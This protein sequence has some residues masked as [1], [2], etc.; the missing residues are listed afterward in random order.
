MN[1]WDYR[2]N[3]SSS[4][5]QGHV[6]QLF[7]LN[8]IGFKIDYIYEDQNKLRNIN[9]EHY[10]RSFIQNINMLLEQREKEGYELDKIT[11]LNNGLKIVYPKMT[12]KSDDDESGAFSLYPKTA[13]CPKCHRYVRLDHNEDMCNCNEKLIQFTF[14]AHCDECGVNYPID[15]MSNVLNDCKQCHL[16]NG[17]RIINWTQADDLLSYS[18]SCIRCKYTEKLVLFRCDHK[19]HQSG[20]IRSRRPPS[21]FRG[22]AARSGSIIHPKILTFPDI[23]VIP[24]TGLSSNNDIDR[25]RLFSNSFN[26]FFKSLDFK[27]Q[28]SLLYMPDF[29]DALK[30]ET[31]FW[32]KDHIIELISYMDLNKIQIDSWDLNSRIKFI[33]GLLIEAY[34][35]IIV[36]NK[37]KK[38]RNEYG[39]DEIEE[40]LNRIKDKSLD[41]QEQQGTSLLL[42]SQTSN[43]S[44]TGTHVKLFPE[45]GYRDNGLFLE[46]LGIEKVA[47]VSN[48]EM[49]QALLGVVEGSM[50]DKPLLFRTIN[51]NNG[52]PTVYVRKMP[53]EAVYFKL[54]SDK[55]LN[56]L[57]YNGKV[58][59]P[60][61][62]LKDKN[63]GLLRTLVST[64]EEIK[65]EVYKL[66]HTFSHTLIQNASIN[67]GLETQ[68]MSEMIFS[69]I[70]MILL[71]STNP[72][73]VGGLEY[74]YDNLLYEW[75]Q[76]VEDLA[77]ECPQDPA[78]LLDEGGACIAC[79]FVPEF[80][81]ENFNN[82]L[83]RD[84]LI[85]EGKIRYK[86]FFN[87][88]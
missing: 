71:Y 44:S 50:R 75:I 47:Y 51:D 82:D 28:E 77:K 45:S 18:I 24:E 13:I 38:I 83:D 30:G 66:L 34:N 39:I 79:L 62:P 87:V 26:Y 36:S 49:L 59:S 73:N 17:L 3:E 72:V 27:I 69:S 68:S 35:K 37:Q 42:A 1:K 46:K 57:Y 61:F 48:L 33:Q 84:C 80:V 70:G 32:N 31:D 10:K 64:D 74:T 60:L 5:F 9:N 15:A 63:D 21:R 81:C 54:K 58:T 11:D 55:I 4:M 52:K 85:G 12:D 23:P 2:V 22:V 56:W 16:E 41:E 8:K 65:H 20:K 78:C 7:S 88:R 67:T 43:D 76:E 86:G 19:D 14:I 25:S 40:C 53:T 6:D 29:W